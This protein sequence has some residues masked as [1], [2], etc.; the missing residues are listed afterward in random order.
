M[1]VL[2]LVLDALAAYRLARLVTHDY[3]TLRPRAWVIRRSYATDQ[4]G[5]PQ[6]WVDRVE[7]DP[8]PPKLAVLVTC[9]WCAGM[10][11]AAAVVA[12]RYLLGGVWEPVAEVLAISTAVGWVADRVQ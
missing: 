5:A 8:D 3:L 1:K 10:Y 4:V 6:A 9:A 2:V 7:E 12:A 11:A